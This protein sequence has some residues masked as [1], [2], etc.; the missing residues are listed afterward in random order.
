[1]RKIVLTIVLMCFTFANAQK[2][3]NKKIKGNGIETTSNRTTATY[4]AIDAGGSFKVVLIAGKEG[5][6]TIKGDENIIPFVITEVENNKLSI[7]FE[8][9]K[10]I[11]YNS[12]IIITVPFED[13]NAVSL[14]GSG[15]VLS[16]K[17]ITATNFE[18]KL[19]GSGDLILDVNAQ[20]LSTSLSG[21][22]DITISGKTKTL[23][24]KIV[25]SGD[26]DCSKLE[27]EDATVV[28]SGSGDLKV[29]CS[30]HLDAK[31]NGSGTIK[32]KSQPKTISKNIGGSGDIMSY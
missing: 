4:D 25:G 13:I 27:S 8:K 15:D 17:T 26:I 24:A 14:T 18:V 10:S 2:G 6:I 5:N 20:Q 30:N 23:A 31:V 9:N 12:E 16:K 7:Y 28:V 32:Y 3:T 11:S 1:M 21:S 29:N 22:G 19:S